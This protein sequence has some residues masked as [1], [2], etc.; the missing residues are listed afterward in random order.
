MPHDY[1]RLLPPQARL[2]L[3]WLRSRLA[4]DSGEIGIVGTVILVVGFAALATT[5]AAAITGKLHDWISQIP[6]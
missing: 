5:L 4:D 6:G 3:H 2:A 1:D